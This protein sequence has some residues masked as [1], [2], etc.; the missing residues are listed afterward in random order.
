MAT[1]VQFCQ[2]KRVLWIDGGDGST[3]MCMYLMP[4]SCALENG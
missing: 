4:M 1:E 3:P 2:M